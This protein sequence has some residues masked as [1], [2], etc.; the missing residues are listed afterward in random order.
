[1]IFSNCPWIYQN[2]PNLFNLWTYDA[3]NLKKNK[4]Y[5]VFF[6]FFGRKK[7]KQQNSIYESWGKLV[8]KPWSSKMRNRSKDSW[9]NHLTIAQRCVLLVYFPVD[10][11]LHISKS[12]GKKTGKTH[13]NCNLIKKLNELLKLL[14]W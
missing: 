12:T 8:Q 10:L 14:Y 6:H 2:L 13:L 7:G 5:L 9:I 3:I 4:L 11:L 1:M